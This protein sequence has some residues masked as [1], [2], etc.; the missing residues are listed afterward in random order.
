MKASANTQTKVEYTEYLRELRRERALSTLANNY[1]GSSFEAANTNKRV[2]LT[3]SARIV[4]FFTA[5]SN[6]SYDAWEKAG[7]PIE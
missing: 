3:L 1:H 7:R 2:E 4:A 5:W 6:H